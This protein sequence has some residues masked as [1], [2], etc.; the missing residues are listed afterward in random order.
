MRA[1]SAPGLEVPQALYVHIPFCQRRCPYCDF[2]VHV[3]GVARF[4][5]YVAAVRAELRWLAAGA[6]PPAP[7]DSVYLGGGTPSRLPA[8]LIAGILSTARARFGLAPGAEVTLEANPSD[9]T[10]RR[11]AAWAT[12]GVTRVSLGVQSLDDDVLRQ[13]G[14]SHTAAQAL[15][16]LRVLRQAAIPGVSCDLLYGIPGRPAGSFQASLAGLIEAEPDHVSCYELTPERGTRLHR[17]VMDGLVRPPHPVANLAQHWWAVE[18]L[19]ASGYHQYEVSNFARPGQESRH[20]LQYWRGAGYWAAGSGAH[21]HLPVA[22]ARRLAGDAPAT[23]VGLGARAV[24]CWNHRG[25]ARY[26]RAVAETGSGWAGWEAVDAGQAELERVACGLRLREGV[27]LRTPAQRRMARQLSRHGLLEVAAG[28][29]RTT[30]RG[31]E[32]LE[33]VTLRLLAA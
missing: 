7:L 27:R 16:A 29:A 30:R 6:A 21:G 11:A 24:R 9:V 12:A 3:G 1:P 18:R 2:A 32:L 33:A 22:V 20:N 15:A 31:E 25:T 17:Q 19:E 26:L 23:G 5:E 14:R 13:L 8:R 4:H 28:R 10:R